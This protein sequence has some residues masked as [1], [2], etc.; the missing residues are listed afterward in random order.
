VTEPGFP[1]L[2]PQVPVK[3][4]RKVR[5][6]K[7]ACEFTDL[8]LAAFRGSSILVRT[9]QRFGLFELLEEAVSVK[10]RDRGTPDMETP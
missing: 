9:A 4:R 6:P 7:V 10:V 5:P 2:T 1:I 8:G 3:K